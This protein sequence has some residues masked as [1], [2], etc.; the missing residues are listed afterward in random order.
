M[1]RRKGLRNVKRRERIQ[2]DRVGVRLPK[3]MLEQVGL[4]EGAQVDVLV[5]GDH[6]VIRGIR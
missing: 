5:E 4:T 2:Y 1:M 6:P 3:T